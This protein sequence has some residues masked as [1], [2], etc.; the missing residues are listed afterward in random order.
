MTLQMRRPRVKPEHAPFRTADDRIRL[1]SA[2]YGIAAEVIDRTGGVWTLLSAMDGTRSPNEIVDHVL[3]SHPDEKPSAVRAALDLFIDSGFVEDVGAPEPPLSAREMQRYDRSRQ[4]YRWVDPQPRA[5]SWEPQLALRRA[6]VIVVG[7]GGTGGTAALALAASGVGELHCVDGD[8]V[9]LSNLNRQVLYREHDVGRAKA[10][11]AIERLRELN[12]DI[13]IT[14]ANRMIRCEEDLPPLVTGCDVF[15]LCADQPG[16][17]RAWVNRA[18]L[19][20][21]TPWVDAGYHGPIA[22]ASAYLPGRGPCYECFWVAEFERQ[23]ELG[24][25]RAYSTVR[26]GRNAVA[27][28][29]AGISGHLAAHA[30][31]ALVTGAPAITPGQLRGV[32]LV[33]P[34]HV[35]VLDDPWRPDCPACGGPQ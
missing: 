8:Q 9:E 10:D 27:A 33:M 31:I 28:P 30:A 12:S 22:M 11:A 34:D 2:V 18:C 17:L 35:F 7:L 20:S 1:G 14:G 13:R 3:V 24:I 26:G 6:R 16:Q 5:S 15:V 19:V 21:G 29:A 32:N 25:D 4:F 23:R